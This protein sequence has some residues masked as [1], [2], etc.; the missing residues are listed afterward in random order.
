[1]KPAIGLIEV[2]SVANGFEVTDSMV[3]VAGVELV[4]AHPVCPGK[5]IVL[6]TGRLSDVQSSVDKGIDKAGEFLIDTLI[7]PN[8]HD[9]VVRAIRGITD[10]DFVEALGSI[11]TMTVATCI[12]ASDA[13]R[14][15]ADVKLIE[16]RLAMGLGGKSYFTLTGE[17]G[18]VRTAVNAGCKAVQGFGIVVHKMVI[19][20]VH[21]S[22]ENVVL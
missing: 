21:K 19:P 6:V 12:V 3:K 2:C 18:A 17:V 1:M 4:E 5:F 7:I 9:D 8:I 13:A 10:V 20:K 16:V 14:K 11:E 22:L 15:R